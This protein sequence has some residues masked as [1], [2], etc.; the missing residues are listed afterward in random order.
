[1]VSRDG[2][3]QPYQF[4]DDLSYKTCHRD[5]GGKMKKS[6]SILFAMLFLFTGKISSQESAPLK[7]TQQTSIILPSI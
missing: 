1:M 5:A 2:I 6:F 4:L 3:K 7:L